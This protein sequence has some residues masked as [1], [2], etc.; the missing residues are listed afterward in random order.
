DLIINEVAEPKPL[1][2]LPLSY[3]CLPPS[4]RV[5]LDIVFVRQGRVV[6]IA[7]FTPPCYQ[8]PCPIYKP[9]VPVDAVIELPAGMAGKLGLSIG[10]KLEFPFDKNPQGM[11]D[12][13]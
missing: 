13:A 9:P 8:Q 6:A 4:V 3:S 1:S 10:V 7:H 11:Q 12:L 2:N 5:P